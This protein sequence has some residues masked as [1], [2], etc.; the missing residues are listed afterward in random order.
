MA[1]R[2]NT[3]EIGE[4]LH[5]V[6]LNFWLLRQHGYE[7]SQGRNTILLNTETYYSFKKNDDFLFF[8]LG[9][10]FK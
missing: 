8:I 7:I 6:A 9:E 5:F 3:L 2:T 4:D 1:N 10:R